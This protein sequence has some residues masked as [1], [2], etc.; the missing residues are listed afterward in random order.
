MAVTAS[1]AGLAAGTYRADVTVTATGASGSPRTI[2]VTLTVTDPPAC[3]IPTGLVGAWGFDEASGTT[4]TDASPTA[5]A[6]TISGALRSTTGRFGGALSFDGVDDRVTV[7]DV[8]ALDLTN[9]MTLEAW[10]NP[11]ATAGWRTVLLKE[12]PGNLV[13]ALYGSSDSGR[14]SAHVQTPLES[15]TRGTAALAANT[16]THLASTYDG[17]TLRLFVNGVQ[18]SSRAVSGSMAASAGV[19]GIGGN[20]VWAEWFAGLIDEV[21]VYD[22]ALTAAEIGTDM[23]T[24]VTCAGPPA[25]SA[26]PARLTFSATQ[27]GAS[28]AA[29]TISVSNPGGGT[30]AWTASEAAS[31]LSVAP[32]SGTN[33]GTVAV[34]PSVAGLAAGTYT[35][36]VTIAA[37]GVAGSPKTVAVTLTVD[38]PPPVLSV[39][40]ASLSFS[41]TAGGADPAAKTLTVANTGGGTMS[42]SVS[43]TS[44]W[45]SVSTAA[46]TVTVTPSTAGLAAGTYTA[47]VTVSAPGATG[48]PKAIPVTLTLEGSPALSTSPAVLSFSATEGGSNPASKTISVA[49]SGGGTLSW[50]ASE[51]AAWLAVSPASGTNDGTVTVTP[52]ITGLTAGTY[53]TDVT[54][55]GAGSSN[56]IAVTLTVDPPAPPSLAVSPAGVTFTATQGAASP[57][58]ETVS[59]SNTGSGTLQVT[60]GSDA[61]WLAVGPASA[62]APATLTLTPSTSG[63][64]AGTYTATVTVTATTAGATG[65][66]KTVAV[67]LTV[68]PAGT[69]GLVGA[70]GFDETTGTSVTDSS[71][72]GHTGTLSGATRT[73]AGRFG[74]ALSFDGVDDWVTVPDSNPLDLTTGMTI[75][76]W[77][78]PSAVGTDWRTVLLKEQ[79]GSLVYALYAGDGTGRPATHV[80]TTADRGTSAA[81]TTPP[82][83]WTHLA[84][85]YDR[86]TLRL[87]VNGVQAASRSLT[88]SLRTSTGALKIGGNGIW[89]EWFAGLIDEVRVYN[90][91]LT[92]AE[93]QADMATAVAGG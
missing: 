79:P 58:A 87:Y 14:P 21:R 32:A 67:S 37:A 44:A 40:P 92:A 50:T 2:P 74:R 6:G 51:D 59:V 89:P 31:W 17:T 88:G 12:R 20:G 35:A 36:D 45:L 7:P 64:A 23:T 93:L 39:T 54:V 16:W 30:M 69:P 86:S 4:A 46:D 61:S 85:T 84:A 38:P 41:G 77:I 52:S 27:G 90:R 82:G 72:T 81:T 3:P 78:R 57:A 91:A 62:T 53:T 66:P 43:E 60:A 80:F 11:T 73:T 33:S 65:S 19:L 9:G 48:S 34:T 26:T 10:V 42:W 5:N 68:N 71:G 63:L 8:A 15:D 49:N 76:A 13:Y 70:W 75:E 24:P 22:R 1:V 29:K 83:S 56:T 28:P 55:S 47:D 25:L 18:V